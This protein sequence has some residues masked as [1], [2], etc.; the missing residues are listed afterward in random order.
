MYLQNGN[1]A[2]W[3]KEHQAKLEADAAKS[4]K[5][6][7]DALWERTHPEE[8]AKEEKQSAAKNADAS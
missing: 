4:L 8:A 7:Q 3:N 5:A 1:P 2:N 6:S